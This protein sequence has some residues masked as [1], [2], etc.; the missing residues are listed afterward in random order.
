MATELPLL[1]P[2]IEIVEFEPSKDYFFAIQRWELGETEISPRWP[3][4]PPLKRIEGF[5][6]WAKEGYKPYLPQYWD[7]F[8]R[9]LVYALK[10][11]LPTLDM[12]RFGI[13]IHRDLPGPAAH[14]SVRLVPLH[15]IPKPIVHPKPV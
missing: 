2:P 9:R 8:P 15:E 14:F 13:V 1:L 3:G 7:V 6:L 12:D 10:A 4:A 5:R 11:L